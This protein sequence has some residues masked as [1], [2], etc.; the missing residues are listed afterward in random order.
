MGFYFHVMPVVCCVSDCAF[1]WYNRVC[2]GPA[3]FALLIRLFFFFPRKFSLLLPLHVVSS[4][5]VF[6]SGVL[7]TGQKCASPCVFW[8]FAFHFLFSYS[9]SAGEVTVHDYLF[10]IVLTSQSIYPFIKF[11]PLVIWIWVILEAQ[12]LGLDRNKWHAYGCIP[13]C[14]STG[15]YYIG[16]RRNRQCNYKPCVKSRQ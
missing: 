9:C 8:H 16:E 10:I 12:G 2:S 4:L 5:P 7:G 3:P 15:I 1:D 13:T 14:L 11:S 6:R